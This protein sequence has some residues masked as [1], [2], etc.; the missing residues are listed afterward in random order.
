MRSVIG[1]GR[2]RWR[3]WRKRMKE[4][5]D[6]NPAIPF[7]FWGGGGGVGGGVIVE[8]PVYRK[9]TPYHRSKPKANLSL[10]ESTEREREK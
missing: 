4:W 3:R 9:P 1:R 5:K 2:R 7:R 6:E 10:V 8:P